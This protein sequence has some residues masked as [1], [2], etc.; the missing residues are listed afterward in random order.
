L[1]GKVTALRQIAIVVLECSTCPIRPIIGC[2]RHVVLRQRDGPRSPRQLLG[3]DE[4]AVTVEDNG[5]HGLDARSISEDLIDH[6][7]I[8]LATRSA[9]GLPY[10]ETGDSSVTSHQPSEV[11]WV[12]GDQPVYHCLD[13]A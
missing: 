7:G 12:L 4:H 2:Q 1:G 11:V 9:H 8:G 5:A 10:E 13:G 3:V 6:L